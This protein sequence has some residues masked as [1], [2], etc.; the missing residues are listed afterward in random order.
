MNHA[1]ILAAGQGQRMEMGKDKLLLKVAN[2][3]IIYYAVAALNDHEFVD[4]ITIVV[5][6]QNREEIV[7]IIKT[8][9]FRK[10][11][12]VVL[13]GITRQKSLQKGISSLKKTADKDLVIVHNGA[14]PLPSHDEISQAVE[15]A[16][17][18]KACIVGHKI[19]DTVKKVKNKK[20]ESTIDR[21]DLYAAQTPQVV[22]LGLLKKALIKA[23]K[24]G[25]ETTDEAMLVE[26]LGHKVHMI[27]AH[28]FNFKITTRSD[29]KKLEA[30]FGGNDCGFRVGIGQ[31]SHSF[32]K[33]E[34]GLTL[35]GF[36]LKDQKKLEANSD[37]DVVLHAI[38]NAISQAIGERSLGFYADS[39]CGKQGVKD[40][41][42]YI[43]III[44][45]MKSTGYEIGNIGLMIECKTPKIDTISSKIKKSLSEILKTEPRK[46]GI[47]ATSGEELT[48]FGMGAGIQCFAIV[49]LIEMK[50]K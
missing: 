11:K 8:Y 3:P 48:S 9:R 34:K 20:I 49:S 35:G 28:E 7:K 40:S 17:K 43:E 10:V 32:S 45:K 27:K 19:S 31:D 26:A 47:T 5:N 22:E 18:E 50:Q 42:K 13:G 38:F 16:A 21:S 25:L 12:S 37:G 6:R 4:D 30:V 2:H 39:L 29:L 23:E 24:K 44:E 41:K 46:I 15:I 33:T 36:L 1:I 14:N